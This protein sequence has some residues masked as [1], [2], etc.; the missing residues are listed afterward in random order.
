MITST[1]M[2]S[3]AAPVSVLR[4]QTASFCEFLTDTS[5]AL[6]SSAPTF[7]HIDQKQRQERQHQQHHSDRGRF[8]VREL[9]EACDDQY[10]RDLRLERHVAAD[11]YDRA[12]F[13]DAAREREAESRDHRRI[14]QR[15]N[16]VPKRLK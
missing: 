8:A 16:H 2:I 15:Q 9:L 13:A 14:E 12:V 3:T 1:T 11:E 7:H 10:R 5:S 6:I 4:T